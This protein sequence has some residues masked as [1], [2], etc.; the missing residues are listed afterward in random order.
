MASS[1][2]SLKTEKGSALASA[3]IM[4]GQGILDAVYNFNSKETSSFHAELKRL[5]FSPIYFF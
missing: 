2:F 3:S 5:D 4:E 1:K